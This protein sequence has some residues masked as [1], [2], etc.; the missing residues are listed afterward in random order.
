MV[1]EGFISLER[2]KDYSGALSNTGDRLKFFDRDCKVVDDMDFSNGWTAGDNTA[3]KT[4]ERNISAVGWHTSANVDGSPGAQNSIIPIFVSP[5]ST[6]ASNN[7]V[8][9]STVII[10]TTTITT[11]TSTDTNAT[12][13]PTEDIPSATSTPTSTPPVA[14]TTAA[15]T[16]LVIAA[17]Q[18]T[19]GAGVT[20]QDYIKIFNLTTESIDMSGWKLR[21]R[22]QSGTESSVKVFPNGSAIAPG[23]YFIWANSANGFAATIGAN[24]SSTQTL[25][26]DNSIGLLDV[27]GSLVDALAW[28][29]GHID[30]YIGGSAYPENPAANQQL[31]RK[32]EAGVTKDTQNNLADFDLLTL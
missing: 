2:G 25:A 6:V 29:S 17:V 1:P 5:T 23:G 19:G 21:K 8:I 27:S 15:L 11:A 10:T 4:L 14:T 18:T 20:D 3:K 16:H 22:T 24:V 31:V 30:P 13:T 28:G 26:S 12:S 9:S 7:S 32:F